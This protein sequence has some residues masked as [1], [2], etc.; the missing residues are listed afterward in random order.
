MLGRA[1]WCRAR[2]RLG[3]AGVAI[4]IDQRLVLAN[5]LAFPVMHL[6]YEAGD[7]AGNRVGVDRSDGANGFEIHPDISLLCRGD[8]NGHRA[9]DAAAGRRTLRFVAV[10]KHQEEN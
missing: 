2:A 9:S 1:R 4:D 3:L 5:E 10:A 8:S 6:V 7:L